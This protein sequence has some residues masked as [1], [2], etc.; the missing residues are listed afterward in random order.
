VKSGKKKNNKVTTKMIES[1]IQR[2]LY[3]FARANHSAQILEAIHRNNIPARNM[4]FEE[5]YE[6]TKVNITVILLS[7]NDNNMEDGWLNFRNKYFLFCYDH[8]THTPIIVL[9]N[10]IQ[11]IETFTPYQ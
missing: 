1:N 2:G 4:G 5:S 6:T 7:S 9:M 3:H 8:D 10:Y 11:D